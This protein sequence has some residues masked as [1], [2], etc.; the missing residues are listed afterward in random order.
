MIG[1]FYLAAALLVAAFSTYLMARYDNQKRNNTQFTRGCLIANKKTKLLA[2]VTAIDYHN[3]VLHTTRGGQ[4]FSSCEVL[5]VGDFVDVIGSDEFIR[6]DGI[7]G[8]YIIAIGGH[9]HINR[10]TR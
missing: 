2:I 1:Y 4:H 6:I 5:Q 9:Y 8:H 7:D 3:R 10:L